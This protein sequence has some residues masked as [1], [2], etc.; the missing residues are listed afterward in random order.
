[1]LPFNTT[2]QQELIETCIAC[3]IVVCVFI[4]LRA[5][6]RVVVIKAFGVDDSMATTHAPSLALRLVS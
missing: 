5:Y 4:S 3:I 1:M 2:K 6:T